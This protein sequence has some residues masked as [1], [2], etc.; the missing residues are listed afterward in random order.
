MG[1]GGKRRWPCSGFGWG[2]LVLSLGAMVAGGTVILFYI[3]FVG[4][5]CRRAGTSWGDNGAFFCRDVM[6]GFVA[7]SLPWM[8]LAAV[9]IAVVAGLV[10]GMMTLLHRGRRMRGAWL[11]STAI[12]YALLIAGATWAPNSGSVEADVA[13][14]VL[15]INALIG[16][17]LL[18]VWVGITGGLGVLVLTARRFRRVSDGGGGTRVPS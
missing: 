18:I 12:V 13:F 4:A 15:P 9:S 11:T 10:G 6:S 8:V 14:S 16:T 2:W 3:V 17:G 7:S 5:E 1:D